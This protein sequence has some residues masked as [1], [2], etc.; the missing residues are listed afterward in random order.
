MSKDVEIF[1]DGF[2]LVGCV[3][4]RYFCDHSGKS[5]LIFH[6]ELFAYPLI[7]LMYFIDSLVL[8]LFQVL[9]LLLEFHAICTLCFARLPLLFG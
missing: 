3:T 7:K 6:S 5:L 2:L 9:D 4:R 8:R 1:L